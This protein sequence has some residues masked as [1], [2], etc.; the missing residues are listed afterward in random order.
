M[1]P[2]NERPPMTHSVD[3]LPHFSPESDQA[4]SGDT[5]KRPELALSA[6]THSFLN[7][8][9]LSSDST[10]SLREQLHLVNQRIDDVHRTLRM[11]DECGEGHLCGFPFVQEIQYAPIPSHF[12][13]PMLEAYD[14][15]SDLTEHVDVIARGWYNRL[16]PS[17]HS[18]N[19]LAREFEGNFVSSA[20]S[21]TTTASLLRITQKEEEHLGQYL[22]HFT[23]EV[24][25]ILDVHPSLVI[26]AFMIGIRPSRL[27]RS[28]VERPPMTVPEMLQRA[29]LYVIIETLVVEKWKDQKHP[30]A[31]PSRG[32]PSG[33]PRRRME[34]GEQTIRQ[35]LNI[36]D[37]IHRGHLDRYI[38][39]PRELSLRPKGPMERQ[40]DV[41]V[42][43]PATGAG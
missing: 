4:P 12:R 40:I 24:R 41:I 5:A 32:P 37:L 20:R 34:R 21:K 16:P 43:Y 13:L 30:W 14:G 3:N 26:Q 35:S 15:S 1:L 18:V 25:V 7:P 27:F 9:I 23:N 36:E 31:E 19:Q 11:K 39:T 2:Q 33:L 10:G 42:G 38:M 28:L 29:N 22:A 17:I 8:D 6:S